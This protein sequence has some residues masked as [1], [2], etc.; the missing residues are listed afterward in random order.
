MGNA[1]AFKMAIILMENSG[2]N[3]AWTHLEEV[4]L[5]VALA[6]LALAWANIATLAR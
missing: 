5:K 6:L 2:L 3:F 1:K 4:K